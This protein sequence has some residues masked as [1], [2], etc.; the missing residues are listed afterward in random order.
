MARDRCG[1][2]IEMWA[3]AKLNLFLEVLA[4]RPDGFHEVVTLMTG[5]SLYDTLLFEPN[6]GGRLDL[7]VRWAISPSVIRSGG[8]RDLP[9]P[10]D[11]LV[12]RALRLL[13][14]E[15]GCDRGAR[16]HLV[17]RIPSEAGLGGG[18]SDAAAALLAANTAWELG[19]DDSRLATLAARLG[20]DVPFFL[21]GGTGVCRGRGE[22]VEYL[23][24]TPRLNCVVVR[25]PFGLSTAE[26]YRR[27]KVP[28]TDE[29]VTI[30]AIFQSSCGASAYAGQLHNRLQS[31]AKISAPELV[32]VVRHFDRSTLVDHQLAGSGSSYFGIATGSVQAM[33]VMRRLQAARIGQVFRVVTDCRLKMRYGRGSRF[34]GDGLA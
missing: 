7:T 9:P 32:D 12:T 4:R 33:A 23:N 5:I 27:L 21:R 30:P 11:N 6:D 22:D 13:R 25:P 14:G 34:S 3:P 2:Q 26:V 20:S 16:V 18:S 1:A 19:L 8:Y 29:Q 24:S 31:S 15:T 28:A 17:K 10:E